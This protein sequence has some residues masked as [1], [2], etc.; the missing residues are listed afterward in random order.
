MLSRTATCIIT[1]ILIGSGIWVI[2]TIDWASHGKAEL[3]LFEDVIESTEVAISEITIGGIR[4]DTESAEYTWSQMVP[5]SII[6]T[7]PPGKYSPKD[8]L[9]MKSA[10]FWRQSQMVRPR[11]TLTSFHI[12]VIRRSSLGDGFVVVWESSSGAKADPE[13]KLTFENPMWIPHVPG[14]YRVRVYFQEI[15]HGSNGHRDIGESLVKTFVLTVVPP[16]G[17]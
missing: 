13:G 14:K 12:Q 10:E 5:V 17:A 7:S 9:S 3:P 15:T 11:R 4:V 6:A 8:R 16:T 1:A 2:K